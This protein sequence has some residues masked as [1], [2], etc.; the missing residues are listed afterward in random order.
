MSISEVLNSTEE[1]PVNSVA[2]AAITPEGVT[3]TGDTSRVYPLASV[4]KLITAYAILM[5]AE[6]GAFALDDSVPAHL[7]PSFDGAPTYRELLSHASGIGFR[8]WE[9]EKPPQTKRIYSSAGYEVLARAL[10]ENTEIDFAEYVYEGICKPLGIE[11][12]VEGSAGHGFS[13]SLDSLTALS[14]E[15]LHPQLINM[16]TVEEACTPQ[17]PDLAGIVPGYGRHDPCTWGLGFSLH[18]GKNPHWIGL[19]MPDDTAGHFGQ[20]GTFLWIHRPTGRAGLVLTDEP[21]G[22]WAKERWAKFNDSLWVAMS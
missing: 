13:A 7:L 19:E 1:W 21:F 22:P 6:E 18:G 10:E 11:I 5:A 8:D 2:A 15:F 9:P 4:S 20:S 3:T 16:Q 17:Y 14:Q 12:K